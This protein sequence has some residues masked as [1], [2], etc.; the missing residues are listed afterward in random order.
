MKFTMGT[1]DLKD[2]IARFKNALPVGRW[3]GD[4]SFLHIW[5]RV[6]SP[7]MAAFAACDSTAL[8]EVRVD[9]QTDEPRGALPFEFLLP[10]LEIPKS[11]GQR[12]EITVEDNEITLN[13][14]GV[15]Q[16]IKRSERKALKY[17]DF[18]NQKANFVMGVN[19]KL[20]GRILK[21][22]E[23]EKVVRL[24]FDSELKAII[25][26]ADGAK[27]LVLPVRLK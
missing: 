13:Y 10:V 15:V 3:I 22:F 2:V 18:F 16:N 24:E 6:I 9:I 14:N 8:F 27:G 23:Q 11:A 21:S 20:F 4:D 25:I 12:T 1:K 17:D 19:P 5:V 7:H 26:K